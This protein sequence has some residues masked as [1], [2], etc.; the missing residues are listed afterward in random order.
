LYFPRYTDPNVPQP[1]FT[2]FSKSFRS[3]F[4]NSGSFLPFFSDLLVF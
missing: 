4:A 2:S 1:N 3:N